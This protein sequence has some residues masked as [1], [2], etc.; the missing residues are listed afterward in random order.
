MANLKNHTKQKLEHL[1]NMR[2][3]YVLD[4][5]NSTF[6]DFIITSVGIDV[7]EKYPE[8]SKAVRLR[9]FWRTESETNV[10]TL[11]IEM[12]NRWRTNQ[13]MNNG[14]SPAEQKICDE[15]TAELKALIHDD[16]TPTAD[17]IAFLDKDLGNIDLSAILVP[18]TF[19][20]VIQQRR[21]EI[22]RCLKAKAPLAVIFLCGSTLEGLLFAVAERNPK[23]FNQATAAPGKDGKVRP[24][25]E[26]TLQNLIAVSRELG[27]VGEDV[28]K[29][30]DAVRDF[31]NYI[32]PRQQIRQNFTPRMFTAEMADKVLR[33]ALADLAS[34]GSS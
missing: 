16:S 24:F 11:M 32:H 15:T 9:S 4:F 34:R 20:E 1:L 6:Q 21:D 18:L 30:A 26:W 14:P 7:D 19:Q 5:T 31:R 2:T 13:L 8:G 29:H 10:A 28:L 17:E 33:A 27:L 12:L 25:G 3:G 23:Q 22:E